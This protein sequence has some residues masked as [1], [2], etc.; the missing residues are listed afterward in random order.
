MAGQ[1]AEFSSYAGS[2]QR[3]NLAG[4]TSRSAVMICSCMGIGQSPD[5]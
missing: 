2:D 5:R 3:V 4:E 1:N